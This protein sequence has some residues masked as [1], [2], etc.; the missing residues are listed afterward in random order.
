M[1][2][3]IGIIRHILTFAGG[4]LIA[5]GVTS[6][7][8]WSSVITNFDAIAGAVVTLVGIVA[9]IIAKLKGFS[10]SGMFGGK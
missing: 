10:W 2:K 5:L 9:S 8:D 7:V 6:E 1:D 3:I 4:V